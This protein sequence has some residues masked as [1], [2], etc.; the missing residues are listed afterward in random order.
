[1]SAC[2]KWLYWWCNVKILWSEGMSNNLKCSL[3]VKVTFSW[4]VKG[5]ATI[6]GCKTFGIWSG[7][8]KCRFYARWNSIY[9]CPDSS[10]KTNHVKSSPTGQVYKQKRVVPFPDDQRN[11]EC[12]RYGHNGQVHPEAQLERR[13]SP[14]VLNNTIHS[15]TSTLTRRPH[16]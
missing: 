1:M 9:Q 15:A 6:W 5:K 13:M 2:L 7:W 8:A 4:R 12:R 11:F 14:L 10:N 3:Q 16:M